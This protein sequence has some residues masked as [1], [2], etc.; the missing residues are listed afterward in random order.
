MK[1]SLTVVVGQHHHLHLLQSAGEVAPRGGGPPPSHCRHRAC[2]GLG[3][4]WGQADWSDV[5]V[6]LST[7]IHWS[8]QFEEG[9][10]VVCC[11]LIVVRVV[12]D[13]PHLQSEAVCLPSRVVIMFSQQDLQIGRNTSNFFL[14]LSPS[15]PESCL[16]SWPPCSG[17]Q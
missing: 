12:Q 14:F 6:S 13:L 9:K 7:E 2:V 4:V 1:V 5:H 3:G 17:P 11:P 15:S 16:V 10:V 8:P